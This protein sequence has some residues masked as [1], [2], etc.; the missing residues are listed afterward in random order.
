VDLLILRSW[1]GSVDVPLQGKRSPDGP[2]YFRV[3]LNGGP[4]LLF[5]TFSNLPADD[6]SGKTQNYPSQV[7]GEHLRPQTGSVEH[8]T[9]G[10]NY[11]WPG[12]PKLVPMDAVYHLRFV[13]PHHG[14]DAAVQFSAQGLSRFI[15]ENWGIRSVTI[16]P[17]TTAEVPAQDSTAIARAFADALDVKGEN[18]ADACPLL[19]LGGDS[20]VNWIEQNVHPQTIDSKAV[21]KLMTDLAGDDSKANEREA[22]A[23]ALEAMGP[24]VEVFVRDARQNAAGELR[25]RCDYVLTYVGV[26]QIDDE[27]IR[28][29]MLAT[30]MLEIIGTPKAMELRHRLVAE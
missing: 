14:A 30:R 3:G 5:T 16:Q 15:D 18:Q 22:A 27:D 2:D 13:V 10:Y 8:N 20:T 11:P 26:K 7:P 29:V 9:L 12:P 28:R 6:P 1:D 24:Q 23:P 17:I 21:E 19:V 4:T 25:T